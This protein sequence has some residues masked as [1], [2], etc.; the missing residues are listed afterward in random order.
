ML[1]IAKEILNS[2]ENLDVKNLDFQVGVRKDSADIVFSIFDT[3]SMATD[4]TDDFIK[5]SLRWCQYKGQISFFKV[6]KKGENSY[7]IHLKR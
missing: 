1:K 3:P 2:L 5:T 7:L 4:L 6:D